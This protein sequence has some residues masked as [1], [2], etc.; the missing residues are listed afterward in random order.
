MKGILFS[1]ME[2]PPE[3]EADFNDWYESEHIP[4]RLA[5]TGFSGA[6]RYLATE[7]ARKYLAIY[8]IADLAVLDTP[9][10]Q[11][12]KTAP[13]ERTAR[14]L[15]TVKGFT[16]FTCEQTYESAGGKRGDYLWA[17]GY[18][19][20]PAERRAFE[21]GFDTERTP[22]L[23]RDAACLKVRRFSVMSSDGGPWTQ[24]ALQ[25]FAAPPQR[26]SRGGISTLA[27]KPWFE[28]AAHWLYRVV[29]RHGI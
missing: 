15:R 20:P 13:S 28:Q 25:E 27:G 17:A 4:A 19:V 16:R 22:L 29:S 12:L 10:Y 7:G 3:I 14:M 9:G 5:L 2:P 1:Q 8:E 11:L 26:Y 18:A 24:L 21:E 23:L 6:T